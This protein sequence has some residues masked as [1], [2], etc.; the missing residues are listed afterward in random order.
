MMDK[1]RANDPTTDI[2]W[3]ATRSPAP[4]RLVA[5]TVIVLYLF[6]TLA[7][8]GWIMMTS[9]KPKSVV[10]SYPPTVLFEPAL[11]GYVNLFTNRA[12]LTD[13]QMQKLPP[14]ETWYEA[15]AR[16]EGMTISASSPFLGRLEN[17]LIIASIS[18][19]LTI[20]FGV[21]A[22]YAFTRLPVRAR[23]D[24]LFVILSTRFF[25]PVAIAL[26]MFLMYR[27]VGLIDT[28]IG[29]IALYTAFNLS[30]AVWLLK[31][32]MAD[33]PKEYEEAA[34]VDGYSRLSAFVRF[35]LPNAKAGI[36][37]TTVFCLIFA[38]NEFT[39]SLLLTSRHAQ[40]ATPY[41]PNIL[42]YGGR[43][44]AAIAAGTTLFLLPVMA[45]TIMLRKYLVRGV[46]F[47]AVRG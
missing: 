20:F 21:I 31:G 45:F 41:I 28:Y 6:L 23:D 34:M 7:P 37:A 15:V 18:T 14:P 38:W 19:V 30:F 8:I 10:T 44:W 22:A 4:I 11:T 9:F 24:Q 13:Q 43:E 42:G 46:T 25:P 2:S 29:M 1:S 33:I 36:A 5:G 39:Y 47:G 12:R 17:S 16:D 40:T 35:V 32:F 26:P 3:S 27:H